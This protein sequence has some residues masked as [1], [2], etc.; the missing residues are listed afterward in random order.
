MLPNRFPDHGS[1][2]EY[3]SVDASLWFVIAAHEYLA[4]AAPAPD[5]REPLIVAVTAILDGYTHGTRYGIRVDDDGL[6]ACGVPG[7]QL[8]WMDAKVGDEVITPRIGKP[9]EVQALW[10]NAL[11][12]AGEQFASMADSVKW[13][14]ARRFPNPAAGCLYDVVDA[15]HVAQRVDA[16]VRPNQ[17]LAVGGLPYRLL[18][19]EV[20]RAVVNCVE[21]ELLTPLGLRTLA[22]GD[23]VYRGHYAGGVAERDRAYHQGTAWPWLTGAFVDAWLNVHGDDA[24]H[25]AEAR[26]RFVAPLEAHLAVAGLGHVSEIADGD[27]P[28]APRGCPF[29]AWSLGELI[30]A[31]ALTT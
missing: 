8:T 7:V 12:G 20:A 27:A 16:R 9:V 11:S 22:P 2:P 21:S 6:L 18:D 15:D 23:P 19:G 4:A 28:H 17:I 14:F 10:F 30:R 24:S 13:A 25:R 3:N 1:A 26:H 5:V 29:Q 31:R